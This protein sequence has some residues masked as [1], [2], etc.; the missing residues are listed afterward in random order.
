MTERNLGIAN[1]L[2]N[3]ADA[4][5]VRRITVCMHQHNR[6]TPEPLIIGFLKLNKSRF[7]IESKLHRAISPN[8]FR[9]F[10]NSVI[11]WFR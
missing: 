4:F 8:A 11:E 1:M 9:D 7:F 3:F 5:F 2:S 10:V 6:D